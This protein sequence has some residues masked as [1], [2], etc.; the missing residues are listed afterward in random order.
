[1]NPADLASRFGA[2]PIYDSARLK[3]M[4]REGLAAVYDARHSGRGWGWWADE[5]P[6]LFQT[7]YVLQ[8]LQA[9]KAAGVS[10]DEDVYRSGF[11]FLWR[12]ISAKLAKPVKQ[13]TLGNYSQQAF[14]AYIL[15]LEGYRHSK[16]R[17]PVPCRTAG[18]TRGAGGSTASTPDAV[19]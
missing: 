13:Q 11:A 14:Y 16:N 17:T 9:V 3:R 18:K 7:A 6:S 19:N 4:I 12:T 5:E 10:V 15:S 1:M 2:S 8:G